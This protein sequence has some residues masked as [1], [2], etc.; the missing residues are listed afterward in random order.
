VRF[1]KLAHLALIVALVVTGC[2]DLPRPFMGAPGA[3]AQRLAQPPPAR[4]AVDTPGN[5]LL[6]D[7]AAQDF[8]RAL[9]EALVNE[10]VPAIS[11]P[12]HKGDWTLSVA[13]EAR[14]A[15]VVPS[16][17]V[18][19]PAG[20]A[21]GSSEGKPVAASAWA[22]GNPPTL[23]AAATDAAPG[24]A[25]LL[26]RIE[27]ARRQSDPHSLYNRPA[28]IWVMDVTGAPGD[29]NFTLTRLMREKLPELGEVVQDNPR[30][31]DFTVGGKVVVAEASPTTQRVE[32]QWTVT[33]AKG[34]ERGRVVQ[35]NEIPKGTLDHYWGDVAL[36]VVQEASG[37][38]RDVVL[39]QSGRK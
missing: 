13:A 21:Q 20:E 29:G 14:G 25:A 11:G 38:V 22:A 3:T 27:A 26:T 7:S 35:L 24:I 9:A 1:C 2:G 10:E 15:T 34:S 28:K 5:A 23:V 12:A 30:D 33:D 32:I 17:T 16:F 39:E 36:T 8:A 18:A 37:G 6:A 19:N 4:L 31:V